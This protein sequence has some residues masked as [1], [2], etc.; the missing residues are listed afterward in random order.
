MRQS[1]S[2]GKIGQDPYP[3]FADTSPRGGSDAPWHDAEK[4]SQYSH[5][6]FPR[7]GGDPDPFA[8]H[9]IDP[10]EPRLREERGGESGETI[11]VLRQAQDEDEWKSAGLTVFLMRS[12]PAHEEVVPVIEFLIRGRSHGQS[13]SLEP[14]QDP[15]L[16]HEGVDIG[17]HDRLTRLV[18]GRLDG[19]DF[20]L[21]D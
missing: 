21:I 16:G 15:V 5:S 3:G 1:G 8:P 19:F 20:S 11:L 6:R 14:R 10:L 9:G 17:D 13:L 18:E 4:I 12:W 2:D 7:E